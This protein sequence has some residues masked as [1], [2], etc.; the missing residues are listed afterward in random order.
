MTAV[1]QNRSQHSFGSHSRPGV[2]APWLLPIIAQEPGALQSAGCKAFQTCVLPFRMM[3]SP[4]LQ[5]SSELLSES[6]ELVKLFEVYLVFYCIVA[7]LALKPQDAVLPTLPLSFQSQ[8]I[9]TK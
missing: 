1:G 6:Q 4:R 5:V 2:S 8:K 9:P 3:S 7:D